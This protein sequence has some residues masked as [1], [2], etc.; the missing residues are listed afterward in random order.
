MYICNCLYFT[1]SRRDL[2]VENLAYLSTEQALAD[3]AYFIEYMQSS[4]NYGIQ[5][6]TKWILFGGSYGGSLATWMRV[7]YP[8]LVHGVVA[9]SAPLVAKVNFSGN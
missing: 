4:H 7:K 3:L 6:D 8:H 1:N 2:S 9:S 5:K